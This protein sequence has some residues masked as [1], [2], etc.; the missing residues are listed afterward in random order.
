M[1][2]RAAR[3]LYLLGYLLLVHYAG[4]KEK[5]TKENRAPTYALEAIC[6][7]GRIRDEII[8]L[9]TSTKDIM[10][11]LCLLVRQQPRQMQAE[12]GKHSILT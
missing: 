11:D 8:L 7:N 12:H 3:A 6:K 2:V 10:F 1:A 9:R 5:A 4:R